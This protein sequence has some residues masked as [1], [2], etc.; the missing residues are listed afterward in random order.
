MKSKLGQFAPLEVLDMIENPTH[1]GDVWLVWLTF[2][3]IVRNVEAEKRIV[4]VVLTEQIVP[5]QISFYTLQFLVLE[6]NR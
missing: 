5:C 1:L 2:S 4:G 3:W 6:F